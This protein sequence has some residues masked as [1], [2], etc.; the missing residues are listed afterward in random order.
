MGRDQI[1]SDYSCSVAKKTVAYSPA[2]RPEISDITPNN[3]QPLSLIASG[4]QMLYG[5]VWITKPERH[6]DNTLT[7]PFQE[8]VMNQNQK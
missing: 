2:A 1:T 7:G 3:R 5:S 4:L 8:L 6:T